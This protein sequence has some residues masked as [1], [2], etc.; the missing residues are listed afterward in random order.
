M[1]WPKLCEKLEN[2]KMQKVECLNGTGKLL[3]KMLLCKVN[4][5]C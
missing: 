1:S 5:D 4:Q 2:T 3:L